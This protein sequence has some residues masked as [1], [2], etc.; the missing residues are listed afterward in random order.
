MSAEDLMAANPE[1]GKQ[2]RDADIEQLRE[3]RATKPAE[4][5]KKSTKARRRKGTKKGSKQT[6]ND[7]FNDTDW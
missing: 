6:A 7:F 5:T 2:L 1:L 4:A 3:T